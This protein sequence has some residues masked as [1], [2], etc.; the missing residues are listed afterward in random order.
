MEKI[1]LKKLIQIALKWKLILLISFLFISVSAVT[2]S[3]I[4]PLT[5]SSSAVILPPGGN[6]LLSSFLP[7]SMTKGLGGVIGGASSDPESGINKVFA[8][9]QSR[10]LA[11]TTINEFSLME[12]Y[13]T[14]T[15][16]DAIIT[17]RENLSIDLSDEATVNLTCKS[18]TDF[19]HPDENEEN[20]FRAQRLQKNAMK[21][22]VDIQKHHTI[23]ATTKK[24]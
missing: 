22:K 14:R 5:Y 18:K 10:E 11:V 3:L 2:I 9:L 6:N 21:R 16:E 23:Q 7:S 1:S 13:E 8:I 15:I 17:F 19:F 4:I 24:T 12:E 20:S